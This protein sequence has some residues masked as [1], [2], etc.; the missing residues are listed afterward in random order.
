VTSTDLS[1][2]SRDENASA[3]GPL[4]AGIPAF[5][6]ETTIAKVIIKARRF[7]DEVMVCDDGSTDDTAEIAEALGATVLRHRE[8]LGKGQA[9]RTL[10]SEARRRA[11]MALVTIDADDQHDPEDIPRVIG[12]VIAG[13]ADIVIGSRMASPDMPADRKVGNRILGAVTKSNSGISVT[14]SQSG[15]R[16]YSLKAVESIEFKDAGMATESQTLIDAGRLDLRVVE[17]TVSVKYEGIRQKRSRLSHFS[18]VL[19]YMLMR[20]IVG[21]PI[22]YLGLPGLILVVAGLIGGADVV[23]I[24]INTK[25]FAIGTVLLSI[26]VAI[27]G[28]MMINTSLILKFVARS[29]RSMQ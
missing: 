6:E 13:K 9:L 27:V 3:H 18:E 29:R 23:Q 14:D 5:N 7:V 21:S 19:D 11:P 22:M 20:T 2:Q 10:I 12:P 15:F 25:Q 16:A 28:A 26:S 17:V 4:I 24:Y 1:P 8:N